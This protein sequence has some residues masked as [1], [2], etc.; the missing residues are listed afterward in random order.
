MEANATFVAACTALQG[1]GTAGTASSNG[2]SS[3]STKNS[4]ANMLRNAGAGVVGLSTS[5][6]VFLGLF[7]L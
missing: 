7:A 3:T 5:M 4:A 6:V 2:I 1:K